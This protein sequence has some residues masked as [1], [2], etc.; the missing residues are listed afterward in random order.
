MPICPT[1]GREL[2][3][4]QKYDCYVCPTGIGKRQYAVSGEWI[5]RNTEI[6]EGGQQ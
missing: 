1:C 3:Y 4:N 2:I 5:R 6:G